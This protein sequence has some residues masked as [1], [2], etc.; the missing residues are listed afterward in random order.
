VTSMTKKKSS[1]KQQQPCAFGSYDADLN[2]DLE[3]NSQLAFAYFRMNPNYNSYYKELKDYE[4][5]FDLDFQDKSERGILDK[6]LKLEKISFAEK[7]LQKGR[8]GFGAANGM[9]REQLLKKIGSAPM[10]RAPGEI[11]NPADMTIEELAQEYE[12]Q[13]GTQFYAEYQE[14]MEEFG[15]SELVDPTTPPNKITES[16]WHPSITK[17]RVK[18]LSGQ[19]SQAVA[20]RKW[21]VQGLIKSIREFFK[22]HSGIENE[23]TR[24]ESIIKDPDE[25]E[26]VNNMQLAMGSCL[27]DVMRHP[28]WKNVGAAWPEQHIFIKVPLYGD[29]KHVKKQLADLVDRFH[30]HKKESK[31]KSAHKDRI[32]TYRKLMETKDTYGIALK[33]DGKIDFITE[34]RRGT[35]RHAAFLSFSLDEIHKDNRILISKV[36]RAGEELMP[37]MYEGK[38]RAELKDAEDYVLWEYKKIINKGRS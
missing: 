23:M 9:S 10:A 29:S 26:D 22:N 6:K 19:A 30:T 25:W 3:D 35:S 11:V 7:L 38:V 4:R 1:Q 17:P 36:D 13:I 33:E 18:I 24:L 32:L 2:F 14:K 15:L 31:T 5:L 8:L 12:A 28:D 16:I 37:E 21:E 20:Y 27:H 34:I